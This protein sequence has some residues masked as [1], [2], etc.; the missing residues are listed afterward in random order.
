MENI[1]SQVYS[2]L[3][4]I[5]PTYE[6]GTI[7]EDREYDPDFFTVSFSAS[8]YQN[9]YDNEPTAENYDVAVFF[10]STS[11]ENVISVPKQAELAL[12]KIGLIS[13]GPPTDYPS[14]EPTHAGRVLEFKIFQNI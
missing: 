4:A 2:T 9:Y 5:Y 10:F 8:G 12:S 1:Q 14:D 13:Q 7:E 3:E 6:H 11:P